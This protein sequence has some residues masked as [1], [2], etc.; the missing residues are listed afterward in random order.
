M[1]PCYESLTVVFFT[2]GKFLVPAMSQFHFSPFSDNRLGG[3]DGGDDLDG[4]AD[5]VDGDEGLN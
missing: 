3:V 4:S 2:I 5:A 1:G